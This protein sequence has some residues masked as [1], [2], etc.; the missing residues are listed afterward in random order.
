[1]RFSAFRAASIAVS[2]TLTAMVLLAGCTN[3]PATSESASDVVSSLG[4]VP[5]PSAAPG[6]PAPVNASVG[7]PQLLAMGAPVRVSLQDGASALIGTSGPAVD[8]P[9]G[10]AKPDSAVTGVI[11][12]T[13]TPTVGTVRLTATDLQCRDQTGALV[14]LSPAGPTAVDATPA[15]PA[16]LTV[17]GTF[18][19]GGAQIN[20]QQNGHALAMWDFTVEID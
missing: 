15:H 20:W 16:K 2:G 17:T 14:K 19:S 9:P 18:H 4:A 12:L 7:H 3:S 5:I 10:G 11:T 13:A 1:M 8:V 6:I